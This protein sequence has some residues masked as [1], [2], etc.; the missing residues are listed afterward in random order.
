MSAFVEK[1]HLVLAFE[2]HPLWAKKKDKIKV[3]K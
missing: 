3:G 2:K 1:K